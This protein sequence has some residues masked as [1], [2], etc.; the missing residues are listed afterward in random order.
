MNFFETLHA[1]S[2][3]AWVYGG[4]F[5]LVLSILV[6]VHEWGHYIVAR[7][8]NVRVEAFSIGFGKELF[9]YNDRN[10]TRWKVALI[11]LGGYVKLYGDVDP[12]SAHHDDTV[13]D[14][15][16]GAARPMTAEERSVA[17][18]AK[19]VWQR[20]LVVF[21]GPAI[22]YI[23]AI[24]LLTF[25]YSL[26]GKPVTPPVAAG[27]IVESS[28]AVAGFL[29]HD[30]VVEIDGKAIASFEEIR[31]EMMITLDTPKHFVVR[32]GD[33]LLEI[34]ATPKKVEDED[35]FGF[36]HSRG[37]LGLISPRHA[38]QIDT[39]D[40]INGQPYADTESRRRALAG[41]MGQRFTVSMKD[42]DEMESLVVEPQAAFNSLI[43]SPE[44]DNPESS[45]LFLAGKPA[46]AF[47]KYDPFPAFLRAVEQS[48]VV[49][50]GTLEALGQ[51]VMGTRSA[52]ELG[53]VIRIGALAGD[54]A[55]QGIVALIIFTALLSINLGLIN[56]FPIPMLDGGHLVFYAVE[57]VLGKPIPDH[58]QEY[59]FR[60][61][62][63]FLVFVMVFA[64]INDIVQ[65]VL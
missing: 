36:K 3:N 49:T 64:N 43:V 13:K 17:F 53:G 24:I 23:F 40:E 12:A 6:F 60:F 35:R 41:L 16:T 1:I 28:A 4:T 7:L 18:F 44:A 56:M 52:S 32:R 62:L 8:C 19:P 21:A 39:I 59:A 50:T 22:N 42:G 30:E 15:D 47:V 63:V 51:M 26:S 11:P 45:V 25:L 58:V 61:G 27:V 65:L 55:Q 5:V 34:D 57:S 46:S 37:L 48:W 31:Q 14:K 9:G 29:P 2:A 10:G 38:I 20:A 33:E 54:M